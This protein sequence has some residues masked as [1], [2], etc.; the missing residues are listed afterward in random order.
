MSYK[1][2]CKNIKLESKVIEYGIMNGKKSVINRYWFCY[3]DEINDY[4]DECPE[5]CSFYIEK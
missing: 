3:A 5:K 4:I 1:I 2:K